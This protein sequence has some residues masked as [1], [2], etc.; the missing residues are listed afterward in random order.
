M[1]RKI[2]FGLLL[3]ATTMQAGNKIYSPMVKT[4]TTIVNDDWQN[5]PVM[6]LGTDDV[7]T[8]G[9]DELSHDAHRYICHLTRC[10]ADWTESTDVF[11]SDWLQGFNDYPLDDYRNSLNTTINYTHYELKIPNEQCSIRMS[12]NYR[13]SIYDEDNGN[14]K[15]LDAEFYVVEPLMNIGLSMTT[16]T[17][18]DLNRGHQQIAMTL[19]YKNVRV[20]RPEEEIYTVVMQNWNEQTARVNLSPQYTY[21]LGLRWEHQRDLIFEAGNEYHKFEVLDVSHP[22]MGIDRITW[23]GEHYQAYPF[24]TTVRRNYLTNESANGAFLIRNSDRTE[25]DYTCD[26]V[27]VNYTLE[28]SYCGEI[29][30][31]GQW[32]NNAERTAYQMQY[33]ATAQCYRAQVMQKQG[34]YSYLY[35][36]KDGRTAPTEGN[37]YQTRNR[38]QALVYYKSLGERTWRLVG[39]RGLDA[40]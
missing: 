30:L 39:Y 9:F 15:V 27:W 38:Y 40:R 10:E 22:T 7:L 35:V 13:L 17:D 1:R 25:I 20:V 2:L 8:I 32:T 14:E 23:D 3:L 11:E 34:Y 37:F 4:L 5:R 36:D 18:I 16:N 6:E 24:T 26:Y 29:Y 12:G 33:D 21:Q 19:E 31:Q 28:A